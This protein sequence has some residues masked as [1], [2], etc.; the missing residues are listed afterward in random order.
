MKDIEKVSDMIEC[1]IEKAEDYMEC[2]FYFK[3]TR[4]QLADAIYK[5]AGNK[6][7]D[8]NLLH[9]QVVKIIEE[10]R[11]ANGEPPESMKILY[12]ILHRKHINNV[13]AVKGMMAL[14][15]EQ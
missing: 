10:Y 12:D 14:Y 1:E 3:E 5:I 2:A 15:K 11:E 7:N 8:M 4:P 9:E 6:I 13:A